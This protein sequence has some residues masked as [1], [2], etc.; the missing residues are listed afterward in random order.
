MDRM[1]GMHARLDGLTSLVMDNPLLA[2]VAGIGFSVSFQTVAKLAREHGLPGWPPLY[3]VGIDV[4]IL[5]LVAEARM[6]IT[7]K[8]ARSDLAPRALAWVLA[9]FTV[10][11]NVHGAPA[12]DWLGRGLHAVMPCLWVVFLELTRRRLMASQRADMIPLGR[13]VA[14]PLQTPVL[15]QRM[16]RDDVREYPLA[17]EMEQARLYARDLVRA[18]PDEHRPPFSSLLRKRIRTGRLPEAVRKAVLASKA[19]D[20]APGWEDA[21]TGWVTT[22]MALPAHLAANLENTHAA[23]AVTASRNADEGAHVSSDGQ[24]APVPTQA[25]PVMPTETMTEAPPKLPTRKRRIVV[26]KATDD[27]L[28]EVVMPLFDDGAGVT[29][30]AVVKAV[31]EASGGT[32]IGYPRARRIMAAAERKHRVPTVV[33]MER[34]KA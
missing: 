8:P 22:A 4:G 31:E 10:W 34:R 3:P 27:D 21:V 14:A 30:Y 20:W 26:A 17:L 15:W 29:P 7:M 28:A 33:P 5:A 25:P 13:W 24:P 23:I 32:K 1:R 6:L 11:A 9:G 19:N 16:R 2:A 12:S 18:A